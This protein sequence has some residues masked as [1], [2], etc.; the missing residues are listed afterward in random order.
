MLFC[1]LDLL[2]VH[3]AGFSIENKV[4]GTIYKAAGN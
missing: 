4:G 1:S 3:P 2:W